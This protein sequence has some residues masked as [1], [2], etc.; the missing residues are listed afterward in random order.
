M[1]RRAGA[2]AVVASLAVV[3]GFAYGLSACSNDGDA[4]ICDPSQC[5]GDADASGAPGQG[6]PPWLPALPDVQNRDACEACAK[7]SCGTTRAACLEDDACT[8]LLRCEG[9]ADNPADLQ[10]CEAEHGFSPWYDDHWACVLFESCATECKSGENWGC[11]GRY[12]WPPAPEDHFPV[13]FHF[14]NPRRSAFTGGDSRV[15]LFRAGAQARTCKSADGDC[16]L[17]DLVDTDRVDAS[18]RVELEVAFPGFSR[19]FTG[20]LEIDSDPDDVLSLPDRI[21]GLPLSRKGEVRVFVANLGSLQSLSGGAIDHDSAP[22]TITV[23]D[24][25]GTAAPGIRLQLP[26]LPETEPRYAVLFSALGDGPT[27]ASGLALVVDVPEPQRSGA[28]TVQAFRGDGGEPV[29]ERY[30][31]VRAGWTTHLILYPRPH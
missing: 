3:V 19:N 5:P 28:V 17:D 16:T 21:L 30:A 13:T 29:A 23:R 26:D 9:E 7:A 24:C 10:T 2:L 8:A 14:K 6:E 15:E 22:L 12:D 25:L 20:R 1:R 18:N 27:D 11:V 4:L 31:F